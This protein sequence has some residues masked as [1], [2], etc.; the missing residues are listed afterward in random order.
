MRFGSNRFSKV[1]SSILGFVYTTFTKSTMV[2]TLLLTALISLNACSNSIQKMQAEIY[3]EY[4][5]KIK[6]VTEYDSLKKLNDRLNNELVTLFKEN[7]EQLLEDIKKGDKGDI[8][9]LKEAEKRY[10]DSYMGKIAPQIIKKKNSAYDNA[11]TG[12]GKCT[13]TSELTSL[14]SKTYSDIKKIDKAN[15]WELREMSKRNPKEIQSLAAKSIK[16]NTSYIKAATP[17]IIEEIKKYTAIIEQTEGYEELKEIKNEYYRKRNMFCTGKDTILNLVFN[18]KAVLDTLRSST[19]NDCL[20]EIKSI[21]ETE[22]VFDSV[23]MNK[24]IPLYLEKEKEFYEGVTTLLESSE[25]K[26]L[27]ND[28]QTLFPGINNNFHSINLKERRWLENR[29]KED[30]TAFK[31][32]ILPRDEALQR[33]NTLYNKKIRG[34]K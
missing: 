9:E 33:M 10:V 6:D 19:K 11:I 2:Y 27:L 24:F 18:N 16:Y 21:I 13:S 14:N 4:T 5:E 29:L 22:A 17:F 12:I 23:Y 26:Q 34:S 3:E 15:S 28:V 1:L 32:Y 31:E 8:K 20:S 25:D 7:S 30:S